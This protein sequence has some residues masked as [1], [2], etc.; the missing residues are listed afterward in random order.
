M[1]V[2]AANSSPYACAT[3]ESK[4][5]SFWLYAK[6]RL[7]HKAGSDDCSVGVKETASSAGE[8]VSLSLLANALLFFPFSLGF[9]ELIND[10]AFLTIDPICRGSDLWRLGRSDIWRSY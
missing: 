3:V 7:W 1:N 8:Q 2:S 10:N 6:Y 4:G 9:C 5:M